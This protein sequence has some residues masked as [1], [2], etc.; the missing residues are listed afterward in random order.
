MKHKVAQTGFMDE[1]QAAF[2]AGR[3]TFLIDGTFRIPG[4]LTTEGLEFG[5]RRT[6]RV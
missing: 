3:A 1:P 2:K 5:R 6:A 4:L